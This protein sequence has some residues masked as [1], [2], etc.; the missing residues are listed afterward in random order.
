MQ[1]NNT[2]QQNRSEVGSGQTIRIVSQDQAFYFYRQ[3]G[4]PATSFA[5]SLVEFSQ[6]VQGID[7]VSVQFH[8]ERGDFERWF[9]SLGEYQLAIQIGGLR[10]RNVS[11]QELRTELSLAVGSRVNEQ[12]GQQQGQDRGSGGQQ[13]GG[14]QQSGG[15]GSSSSSSSTK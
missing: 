7:P 5:R 8:I 11:P 15:S 3:V 1:T 9:R 4:Q 10:G 13:G 6:I 12:Q 14:G 2:R